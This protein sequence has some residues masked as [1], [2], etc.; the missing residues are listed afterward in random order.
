MKTSHLLLSDK[1]GETA[2]TLELRVREI[3]MD[4]LVMIKLVDGLMMTMIVDG[5]MIVNGV[6]MIMLVFRVMIILIT[7]DMG[8]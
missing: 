7:Y 8:R 3:I 1:A 6:L 4:G 5:V 2:N